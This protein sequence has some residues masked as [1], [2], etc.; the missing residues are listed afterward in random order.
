MFCI[1]FITE[2]LIHEIYKHQLF[3]AYFEIK[4]GLDI[5]LIYRYR[6]PLM[7]LEVLFRPL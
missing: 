2:I 3:A 5:V 7:T 6:W 1:H 4:T